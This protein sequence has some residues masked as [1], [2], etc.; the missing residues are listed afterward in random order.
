MPKLASALFDA[1]ISAGFPWRGGD[2][3]TD[4]VRRVSAALPYLSGEVCFDVGPVYGQVDEAE[5]R[6]ALR[7]WWG[8]G[9]SERA[10]GVVDHLLRAGVDTPL[11]DLIAEATR[12]NLKAQEHLDHEDAAQFHGDMAEFVF[13]V[14]FGYSELGEPTAAVDWMQRWFERFT[15]GEFAPFGSEFAQTTRAWDLVR[16][17]NVAVGAVFAGY[18]GDAEYH[19]MS[20]RVVVELQKY[21]ADWSQ[22]ARSYWWG[23][24]IWAAT[25]DTEEEYYVNLRG[26]ADVLAA[27]LIAADSPWVRVPLRG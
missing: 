12:L 17:A 27:A 13:N 4:L 5:C 11:F 7:R 19:D 21:F 2:V 23:R 10:R 6:Q 24:A 16:A 20:R 3:D 18:I 1:P 9:S 8:V 14:A 15:S 22:V 26:C 25:E